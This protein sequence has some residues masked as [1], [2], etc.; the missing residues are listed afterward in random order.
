[1]L[2]HPKYLNLFLTRCS[3]FKDQTFHFVARF[4][5]QQQLLYLITLSAVWQALFSKSFLSLFNLLKF[6]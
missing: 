3:V 4:R 1:G 2:F 5:S 6:Q